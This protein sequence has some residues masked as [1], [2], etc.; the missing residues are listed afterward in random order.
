MLQLEH[1]NKTFREENKMNESVIQNGK[2]ELMG[3]NIDIAS[4][5][6]EKIIDQYIA[7]IKPE[8][9]DALIKHITQ[10]LFVYERKWDYNREEYNVN[11]KIKTTR[12]G[13]YGNTVVD[14]KAIGN[15]IKDKFN[16]RIKEE[17]CKKVEEIIAT[18][19]YQKCIEETAN[20]LVE[21]SINGYREDMKKRIL[22]RLSGNVI[23]AEPRYC[24]ESLMSIIDAQIS[25][26]LSY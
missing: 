18:S 21:Y 5:L 20:E 6:G 11:T 17:L 4:I 24:G 12:V 7:Q 8:D 1:N 19:D 23:G 9:M 16:E 10:D 22:E 3:V 25:R 26:R 14:E 2:T 13:A 15:I